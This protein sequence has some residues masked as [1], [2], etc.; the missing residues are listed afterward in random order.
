[1][2]DVVAAPTAEASRLA[3]AELDSVGTILVGKRD[4]LELVLARVRLR[5]R[6][7]ACLADPKEKRRTGR[8]RVTDG[9]RL[10]LL[11]LL[12]TLPVIRFRPL[13]DSSGR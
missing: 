1:M 10:A 12:A 4:A 3:H 13:R 9:G 2:N 7:G 5:A 8:G 6:R 11:V